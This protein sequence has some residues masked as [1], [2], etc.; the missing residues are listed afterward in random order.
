M[1]ERHDGITPEQAA[2]VIRYFHNGENREAR[3]RGWK[4]KVSLGEAAV[5]TTFKSHSLLPDGEAML[6]DKEMGAGLDYIQNPPESKKSEAYDKE[7]EYR[8]DSRG[9]SYD[10]ARR[11]M[12]AEGWQ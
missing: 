12:D 2:D 10:L 6:T 1:N 9:I 4:D 8:V 3:Q 7:L 5:H 11:E